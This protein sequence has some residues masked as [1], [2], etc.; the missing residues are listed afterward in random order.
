MSFSMHTVCLNKMKEETPSP[1]FPFVFTLIYFVFQS[2]TMCAF[3]H[4]EVILNK[5][6]CLNKKFGYFS[7][8]CLQQ[9]R[10]YV[11]MMQQ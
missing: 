3:V 11:A 5:K 6:F 7:V 4:L 2:E 9:G 10:H 1:C 8:S